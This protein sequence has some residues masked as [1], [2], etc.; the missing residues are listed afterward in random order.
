MH[1]YL[2]VVLL[3]HSFL[4]SAID[5]HEWSTSRPGR[6]IPAKENWFPP[7]AEWAPRSGMNV[8]EKRKLFAITGIRP[9]DR[10]AHN[11]LGVPFT[12]SQ[13]DVRRN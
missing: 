5:G 2:E 9:P 1:A 7:E 13:K 11:Q 6:F 4:T 8:L 3:L 12:L 10:P